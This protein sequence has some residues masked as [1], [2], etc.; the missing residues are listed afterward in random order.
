[1][2]LGAGLQ[3]VFA[4][5]LGLMVAAFVGVGVDTFYPSPQAQLRDQFVALERQEQAIRNSAPAD[6]LTAEDRERLQRLTRERNQLEDAQR[7]SGES[8]GRVTSII[9]IAFAT[10]VMAISLIQAVQLPVISNGL[11]LGG[12]FTMLYGIGW[13]VISDSSPARFAVI[14]AAL[15]ITIGLGYLRFVKGGPVPGAVEAGCGSTPVD[16]QLEAR[17][18]RLEQRLDAAASALERHTE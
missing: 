7:L 16:A 4:I 5:F 10:L 13:I 14:T 11:L 12:L 6:D 8:W 1:M 3:T 2:R 9:L 15:A 18:R 17:V